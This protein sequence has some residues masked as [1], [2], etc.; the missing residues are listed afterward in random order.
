MA[1]ARSYLEFVELLVAV[2]RSDCWWLLQGRIVGGCCKVVFRIFGIVGGCYKV[3]VTWHLADTC[4]WLPS[5]VEYR[6]LT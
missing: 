3:A 5:L 2:A 1:V 6:F 4:V